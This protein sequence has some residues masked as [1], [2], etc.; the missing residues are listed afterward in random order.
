ML[1]AKPIKGK[2]E[3][4]MNHE[5]KGNR[6]KLHLH[7][8]RR[9]SFR[10]TGSFVLCLAAAAIAISAAAVRAQ[11]DRAA[12]TSQPEESS[13]SDQTD[14]AAQ[15][16]PTD[17]G[18]HTDGTKPADNAGEPVKNT[19]AVSHDTAKPNTSD[20]YDDKE[21]SEQTL[22]IQVVGKHLTYVRPTGG[23]I[24][25]GYSM[26]GLVYSKTM[27]DWRVHSGTDLA[28]NA[29]EAVKSAA[30]GKVA[31]IV[32]DPLYGTTV[33]VNQ[34]DGLMVYYSG[35]SRDVAV[36]EGENLSAGTVIGTVGEIPCESADGVHL[37]IEVRKEDSPLD[38]QEALGLK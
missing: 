38:P 11:K 36:R 37:H 5:D 27:G 15:T 12:L 19:S 8:G 22:A 32:Q 23:A 2:V 9:K 4:I 14:G 7:R 33:V 20:E 21:D 28:A 31:G 25:K 16:Y 35:L 17:V 26:D 6:E 3:E 29:G 18:N 24:T 13:V 30:E 10:P 34:N 1:K